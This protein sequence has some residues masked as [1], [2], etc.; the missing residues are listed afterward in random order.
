MIDPS[1]VEHQRRCAI[2]VTWKTGDTVTVNNKQGVVQYVYTNGFTLISFPVQH[3]SGGILNN[4]ST[5]SNER[6]TH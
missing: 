1:T 5:Y 4:D 6:I 3:I 2:P